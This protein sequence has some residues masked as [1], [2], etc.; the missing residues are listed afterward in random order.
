M[1][2][3]NRVKLLL[4][5]ILLGIAVLGLAG[6]IVWATGLHR[7]FLTGASPADAFNE[8]PDV[9]VGID[10]VVDW[11]PDVPSPRD[12]EPATRVAVE[13]AW[14]G[15]FARLDTALRSD[16]PTDLVTS[17]SGAALTQVEDVLAEASGV[18]RQVPLAHDL[19]IEFYSDDGS[20]IELRDHGL[21]LVRVAEGAGGAVHIETVESWRAVLLL[22]DGRWRV[23]QLIREDVLPDTLVGDAADALADASWTGVNHLPQATPWG[24][25]WMAF[26]PAV[27]AADLDAVRDLGM[28]TVRVFLPYLELGGPAPDPVLLDHVVSYLDLAEA[29]GIGVVPTLFDGWTNRAVES[30]PDADRHLAVVV[31]TLAGHPALVAWDLKNEADRDD[32]VEGAAAVRAWLRHVGSTVRSLDAETPRTIGWASASSATDLLDVV[33]V[34]TFHH[35]GTPAELREAASAVIASAGPR[36]VVLGEYGLPTWNTLLPGGHGDAEQAAYIAD[37][38]TVADEV[39]IAGTLVWTLHDLAT[40]PPD[41]G[42][43]PWRVGAETSLG[44]IRADGTLKPAAAVVGEDADLAAVARPGAVDLRLAKPFWRLLLGVLVVVSVA[45]VAIPR[46]MRTSF[47]RRR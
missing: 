18:V 41:A 47:L 46:G 35:Y 19:Q 2:D 39:G 24:D 1:T 10:P 17:W 32:E 22:R 27:A 6:A 15:A 31:P 8:V 45:S 25:T 29:R 43:S 14:V 40:P 13:A 20:I 44:L 42:S 23:E 12:V 3:R 5:S 11:R 33:E 28:D 37:I 16:D 36:P 9:P 38:R 34:V 7:A 21:R 4:A 30:W 26:D